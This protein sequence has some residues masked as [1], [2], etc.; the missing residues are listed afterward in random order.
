[1]PMA[2]KANDKKSVTSQN[3]KIIQLSQ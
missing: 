1:M 3:K 2:D